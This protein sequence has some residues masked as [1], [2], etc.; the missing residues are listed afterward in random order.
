MEDHWHGGQ[1]W[2]GEDE[3]VE[4]NRVSMR[5]LRCVDKQEKKEIKNYV[6]IFKT[7]LTIIMFLKLMN[8]IKRDDRIFSHKISTIKI[9]DK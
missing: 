1:W 6:F 7:Q 8:W 5:R 2:M 4:E 9:I 3:R